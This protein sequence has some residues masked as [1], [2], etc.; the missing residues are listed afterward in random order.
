M[1]II[2]LFSNVIVFIVDRRD[3]VEQII[4][5]LYTMLQDITFFLFVS[6][7]LEEPD[8][9]SDLKSIKQARNLYRTCLDT[10]KRN[11]IFY[12]LKRR[13]TCPSSTGIHPLFTLIIV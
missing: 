6:E 4:I 5:I 1:L 9:E 10:G 8:L 3:C 7:I 2:I 12:C 11:I 13:P